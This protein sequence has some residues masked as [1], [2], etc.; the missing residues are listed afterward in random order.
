[1]L[2]TKNSMLKGVDISVRGTNNRIVLG[3]RCVLRNC[4]IRISGSNNTITLGNKVSMNAGT[5]WIENDG[6]EINIGSNTSLLG[7][8]HLACIEGTKISIGE[9]CL[10]SDDIYFRTGDSHSILDN[11][12]KRINKSQDITVGNHVWFGFRSMVNKGVTIKDDSIVAN[13]ALVTSS[14]DTTNIII[15]GVPGKVI[16]TDINWDIKRI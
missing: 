10:F 11:G 3:N 5:L 13:G 8:V 4:R 1:M 6:N 12:G 9:R 2:K 7:S 14:F 16:K 15:G